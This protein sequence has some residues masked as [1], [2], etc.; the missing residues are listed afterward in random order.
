[1]QQ[2]ES[3]MFPKKLG[4]S[5][6]VGKKSLEEDLAYI[7]LAKK[8]G[9]SR[10]FTCF[11]F[12]NEDTNEFFKKVKTVVSH[13][14]SLDF[15]V[16]I[17]VNPTLLKSLNASYN[18]L[19]IFEDLG[20]TGIRLD[21]GY[22]GFEESLISYSG[23]LKVEINAS[24]TAK[25]FD[26]IM[27]YQPCVPNL[28]ACHN[29]Y[30]R[31]Y[32]G[33]SEETFFNTSISVKKHGLRLAA[34]VCSQEPNTF[35]SQDLMEKLPTL[36]SHRDLPIAAQAKE[37]F[38]CGLIDDVI[39]SNA[40]ASESDLKLLAELN[41][42]IITLNVELK[43]TS[44]LTKEMLSDNLHFNR[45][46]TS[47]YMIRSTQLRVKYKN[48]SIPAFN[49][50]DIKLGD[51]TIDN[52]NYGKYKGELHVALLPMKNEG[53]VNVVGRVADLDMPLLKYIKPWSKFKLKI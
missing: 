11:M 23:K 33:L 20:I 21:E 42:D 51:I 36:E 8:Y 27:S 34:F 26:N 47:E 44:N 13:A 37:L 43:D 2:Q 19:K 28:V 14:V 4:I 35:F 53:N 22:S 30:P 48:E 49:T 12:I 5:V 29:F 18:N 32:T 24:N 52:D 31:R 9:F 25:L 17:D 6:Y 38:Y 10:I 50:A 16:F 1:M 15:E 41:K 45:G 3:I 39:I 40:Y 7:S 46:D